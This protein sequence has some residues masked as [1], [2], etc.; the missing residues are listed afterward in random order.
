M[1]SGRAPDASAV[2]RSPRTLLP[3]A[4]QLAREI[5]DGALTATA[6][7]EACIER[8]EA[9]D[10]AV[11]AVVQ[12]RFDRA[13]REAAEADAHQAAGEHLGPL[14]GVPITIKD[15][16]NVAGMPTTIGLVSRSR[17]VAST[18]GPLV[19]RLRQA[20]AVVLGKTNVPQLL[21]VHESDNAVF[22]RTNN[23]WDTSRTP[24]G[25]SGGE[26]AV[27]AYGGS[28]LG[29][30]GDFG[31]SIRGPAAFCGVTGLKPTA[32]RLSMLD[33]PPEPFGKQE[34]VSPQPG[35]IARN[36][37]DL[38][39]AMSVLA[40]PG[41]QAFDPR[42]PPVAWADPPD[43]ISQL[44]VGWF[45]D[46]GIF[47]PSP[48]IRRA[49]REA[50]QS[51]TGQGAHVTEVP[52]LGGVRTH[53]LFLQLVGADRLGPTRSAVQDEKVH[54]LLTPM[55][56]AARM[57]NA[58]KRLLGP[59]V[60]ATGRAR[61]ARLLATRIPS[62]PSEYF[63]LLDDRA[64]LLFELM[65]TWDAAGV[66]V[67]VLPAFGLPAP[68][69]GTTTDL[70]DAGSYLTMANL[71]G[72]PAGVVAVSSVGATEETDRPPSRDAS[73]R[74]AASVERGSAGLPV[75]VQVIGR[76]WREDLVLATMGRIEA[77]ARS[78]GSAPG[79]PVDPR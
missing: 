65:S 45:D 21:L 20:G 40:A 56:M 18:D 53:E 26:A 24:G 7:L 27:V 16:F 17:D 12:R 4:A 76:P 79:L 35:P 74:L 77:G 60:R 31:G 62:T 15:Q 73:D 58:V 33:T 10:G 9:C 23:P 54:P 49:V 64:R 46:N 63:D 42:V 6:A 59:G 25:S 57:P 22:G 1:T 75:A 38:L 48:A 61:L 37:E 69:H 70:F 41:Q 14:H 67:L 68:A 78:S 51:L 13:R 66:D 2:E 55:F 36:V 71:F 30:G 28:P 8:I 19:Q 43:D 50:A 39:L 44:R 34:A 11:N 32:Q 29:L 52:P 3:G 72:L 5:R 47:R